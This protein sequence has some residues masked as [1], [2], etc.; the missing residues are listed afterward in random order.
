MDNIY[1]FA[2]LVA[3]VGGFWF[4]AHRNQAREQL[5]WRKFGKFGKNYFERKIEMQWK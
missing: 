4:V 5:P 3:V 2:I 1:Q